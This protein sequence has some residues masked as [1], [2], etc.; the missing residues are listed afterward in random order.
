MVDAARRARCET[1]CDEAR[2]A[3]APRHR[4]RW[5]SPRQGRSI[6]STGVLIDPPNLDRRLWGFPLAP[7]SSARRLGLTAAIERDT[8]VAALAE[9]EFG[10][11]RGRDDFVYM[12]VSTGIGGGVVSDGRLLR[13]AGRRRRRARPPDRRHERAPVRLWR[14]RPPGGDRLGHGHCQARGSGGLAWATSAPLEVAALEE[15]Q[16]TRSR[17]ASWTYARRAFASARRV[18]RRRVQPEP[19][20]GRWRDRHRPG[21]SAA[22]A[23]PRR[24]RAVRLYA[25]RPSACEIV[26]AQ[27]GDDVGLIGALSL[28]RLARV[29]R[30]LG[31]ALR[32]TRTGHWHFPPP[33]DVADDTINKRVAP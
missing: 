26:P 25:A 11:A 7:R 12:T 20:R 10:A 9:G 2:A 17:R 19:A 21:R 16:A 22:R 14:A 1:R 28:V 13:G 31:P 4:A 3:G 23:R 6:P 24:R 15:A 29:R 30:R 5:A 32:P 27:L 8:Q 33:E 18:H